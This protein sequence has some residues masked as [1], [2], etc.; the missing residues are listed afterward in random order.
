MDEWAHESLYGFGNSPGRSLYVHRQ[1]IAAV[2]SPLSVRRIAPDDVW[3]RWKVGPTRRCAG[4]TK[5]A[6][7]AVP[8]VVRWALPRGWGRGLNIGG[9]GLANPFRSSRRFGLGFKRVCGRPEA[10]TTAPASEKKKQPALVYMS[11]CP[12]SDL[13]VV[14][15]IV[16]VVAVLLRALACSSRS[17]R[18]G[19]NGW[20]K[21]SSMLRSAR[22]SVPLFLPPRKSLLF[23]RSGR[24]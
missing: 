23:H 18:Q 24:F 20:N 2:L 21:S 13:V 6:S 3:V 11:S 17:M 15:L 19:L 14:A 5:G 9:G 4:R 7:R 1:R 10:T 8:R 12:F 22:R 16:A